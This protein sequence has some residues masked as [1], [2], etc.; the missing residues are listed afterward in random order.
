[1]VP[2]TM[3]AARFYG[4]GKPI[5]IEDVPI[6][7]PQKGDL[8]VKI[9]NAGLCHSDLM[10]IDNPESPY[11]IFL[12]LTPGH[13]ATG[14]VQDVSEGVTDFKPGDDIGMNFQYYHPC[15]ECKPCTRKIMARGCPTN[16]MHGFTRDGFFAEYV[17]VDSKSCIKLPEGMDVAK[18]APFFCAGL[19]SFHAVDGCG[20]KPGDWI[21]I[22]GVGGL[23]HLGVQYAAKMGLKVAAVDV[24]ESRLKVARDL[25]A[26]LTWNG[27]DLADPA[28]FKKETDGG[29]AA[30]CVFTD[31]QLAYSTAVQ[32][33]D[34]G[35][36]LMCA[37][38][39]DAPIP[40][41]PLQLALRQVRVRGAWLGS[42]DEMDKA[43]SFSHK[44]GV[45]PHTESFT[46][47]Q[48]PE[49]IE[50]M[51]KGQFEGRMVVRF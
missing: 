50:K 2:E 10:V 43:I 1:M 11:A 23:G 46:L 19:T 24:D 7:K 4:Y 28:D 40:V 35:G 29:V 34:L 16:R 21:A 13:E 14:T 22:V 51:K 31:S 25:G 37:G 17:V 20:L 39:P 18:A 36:I 6:P 48:L 38:L 9:R 5:T 45:V 41:V 49:M 47:N 44:H 33:L 26:T 32:I 15:G 8:L 27:K 3:K 12:P 42:P 30:A